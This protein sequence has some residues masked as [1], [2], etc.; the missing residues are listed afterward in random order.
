MH[1]LAKQIIETMCFCHERNIVHRDLKPE[2]I[3]FVHRPRESS[4]K[5]PKNESSLMEDLNF[6]IIDFGMGSMLQEE[7]PFRDTMLGT[8]MYQAPEIQTAASYD[9]KKSDVWSIG[10]LTY[11]LLCGIPPYLDAAKEAQEKELFT[12]TVWKRVSDPVQSK[13]FPT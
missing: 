4:L 1:L 9:A 7:D 5:L 11:L 8:P 13:Q 3:L 6:K 10:V 12:E 2:N